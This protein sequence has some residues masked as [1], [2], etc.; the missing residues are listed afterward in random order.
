MHLNNRP[1]PAACQVLVNL[2]HRDYTAENAV[3]L[4]VLA[5]SSGGARRQADGAGA[6][7]A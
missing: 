3:L 1:V 4:K 5:G 7:G 2:V 6:G